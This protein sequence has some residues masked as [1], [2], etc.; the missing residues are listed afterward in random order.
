MSPRPLVAIAAIIFLA[1]CLIGWAARVH[2]A[3]DRYITALAAR[4]IAETSY[5]NSKTDQIIGTT[6]K[7][8]KRGQKEN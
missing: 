4:M 2:V 1:G 7:E 6:R 5:F 3:G 8:T